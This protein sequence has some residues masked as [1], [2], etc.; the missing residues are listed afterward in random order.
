MI[1]MAT[2]IP[3]SPP[4]PPPPTIGYTRV[5]V[6]YYSFY[7]NI[8]LYDNGM[9]VTA[10]EYNLWSYQYTPPPTPPPQTALSI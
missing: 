6:A 10:M 7:D 4:P 2:N 1:F 8:Q 5:S 3:P 9:K